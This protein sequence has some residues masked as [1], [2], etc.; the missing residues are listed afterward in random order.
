VISELSKNQKL[1][2]YEVLDPF[3][4]LFNVE[5]LYLQNSIKFLHNEI[6]E[7]NKNKDFWNRIKKKGET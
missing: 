5:V 3:F 7:K 4:V 2:F 6:K 1:L